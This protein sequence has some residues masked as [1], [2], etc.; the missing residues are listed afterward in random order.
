MEQHI[1][2]RFSSEDDLYLRAC[3]VAQGMI[4]F[5]LQNDHFIIYNDI[6]LCSM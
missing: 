1:A 5:Q 6:F 2:A 4:E 3:K